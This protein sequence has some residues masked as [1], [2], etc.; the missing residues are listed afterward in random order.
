M[1]DRIHRQRGEGKI[2]CTVTLLALA[3]LAAL[4]IKVVPVYYAQNQIYDIVDRKADQA[5]GKNAESIEKEIRAEIMNLGIPE[6][7]AN[8][9]IAVQKTGGGEQATVTISLKYTH[10]IDL[11]GI[12]QWPMDVDKKISHAVY[13]N[14]R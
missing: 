10:K 4:A 9:A 2:G 11:Y 7:V 5:A 3:L 12:T 6:A 13:E 8:H 1:S 14:I